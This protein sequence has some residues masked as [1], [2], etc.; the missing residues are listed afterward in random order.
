MYE[1]VKLDADNLGLVP[2]E[3]LP[4]VVVET[5]DVDDEQS[6]RFRDR[7]CGQDGIE[8]IRAGPGCGAVQA[9]DVGSVA[10]AAGQLFVPLGIGLNQHPAPAAFID[11]VPGV[12][13]LPAV[14]RAQF[15]APARFREAESVNERSDH[16]VL[17]ALRGHTARRSRD[18]VVLVDGPQTIRIG[19]NAKQEVRIAAGAA[20]HGDGLLSGVSAGLRGCAARLRPRR[21]RRTGVQAVTPSACRFVRAPR[22]PPTSHAL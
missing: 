16:A 6:E 1:P 11:E 17:S 21:P 14:A 12:R 2:L 10:V 20:V 4:D 3:G 22:R 19:F 7:R 13:V 9:V 18:P 8:A 5:I 15:D